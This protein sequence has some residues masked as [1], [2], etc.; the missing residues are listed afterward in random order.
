MAKRGILEGEM[1]GYA[2]KML[3]VDLSKGSIEAR[4]T[5]Q[6]L[7]R[8]YLGG[9][10]F[11]AAL[12][13]DMDWG[14]NPLDPLNRLVF[15]VG[16]LTGA[17]G[18]C[19]SRYSVAAKSP[20]T[21]LYGEAH[22][23]GFWG[24]ELKYASW[25]AVVV[26]GASEK[27]VYLSIRDDEVELRDGSELW[28]LD[29]YETEE[30]LQE[31]H[32][33]T[34]RVLCIGPAGEKRSFLACMINDHGRAAGRTGLG[35]VMGSKRLKAVLV[36]GTGK[37]RAADPDGFKKV[38]RELVE[39][40]KHAPAREAL[41]KFG[42][43]GG[44]MAFHE[45]GD[46]PIRNWRQ[47]AWEEGTRKVSGQAMTESILTGTYACRSCPI[48]C[49]RVVTVEEGPYAVSGK[50]PEYE[51]AA[52]FGPLLLNDNLASV[53]KANDLCNRYGMDTISTSATVGFAM[54]CYEKGL[55]D[56]SATDG[57][58][59]TW[60]NHAAIVEVVRKMGER[61]GIGALLADGS[62]KAAQ[63][64]GAGS[65]AFAIEVKGLELPFHDPRAFSS[66]AVAYAT[67]IRGG[68]HIAAPTYWLERG[69][70]FEDL[71][72]PAQLDRFVAEGKGSWTKVFQDYCEMLEC[73]VVCKFTLYGKLRGPNFVDMVRTATGWDV[74]LDEL[75]RV[76]ER[77][78]NL[79]RVISNRLGVTRKDDTLP[80]RILKMVLT[81]GGAKGF[82]PDLSSMLDEYYAARGWDENGIP[83]EPTLERLGIAMRP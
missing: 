64:I 72:Y 36:K 33:R 32:G 74:T 78:I 55:L 53:A 83:T 45:M 27:P 44:M 38:S 4:K 70:T 69:V 62:R 41:H 42:T 43:N 60:G 68:C 77:S 54:E 30:R 16:P 7:A 14:I 75:I 46:V 10:G 82:K 18:P 5:D 58:E 1:F 28:G 35:A 34:C 65:R 76:G 37:Y 23:S 9:A 24:P 71:G 79:K 50:G 66:W 11:C 67:A 13:A 29:T 63:S 26:V 2:G 3:W 80:E 57:L 39:I 19:C 81:E 8:N 73:L 15:A 21:G 25:D 12:T 31:A 47:G 22:A 48:G 49:G 17:P 51:T 20:L 61:E 56:L 59:L 6:T 52:G 40:I